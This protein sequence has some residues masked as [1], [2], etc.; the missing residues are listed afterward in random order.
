[1]ALREQEDSRTAAE[2]WYPPEPASVR[3]ARRFVAD[4]LR[5]HGADPHDVAL[6]VSEVATN[7]V[8]HARTPFTVTVR[9]AE[10]V[11]VDIADE[12]DTVPVLTKAS[13]LSERGRGLAI[14]RAMATRWGVEFRATGKVVWFEVPLRAG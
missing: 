8:D 3:S 5:E 11:R 7:A 13:S 6:L 9:I 2:A 12:S 14:V 1:M 4:V 10:S